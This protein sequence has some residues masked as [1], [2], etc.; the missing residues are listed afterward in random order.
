MTRGRLASD[1]MIT[2]FSS[3]GPQS[4]VREAADLLLRTNQ[5]EFPVLD[6]AQRLRGIVTRESI[7]AALQEHGEA[8]P[9]LDIMLPSLPVVGETTCIEGVFERMQSEGL[10]FVG[11]ADANGRFLGYLTPENIAEMVMIGAAQ[12][13]R[14]A[15]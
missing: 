10:H 8:A 4:S 9:V 12:R 2:V 11:I 3:L 1:A 7:V 13:Q 14:A 5:R 15:A 6:G